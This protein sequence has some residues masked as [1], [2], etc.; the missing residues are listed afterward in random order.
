MVTY[1]HSRISTFEQCRY[2][3]KLQYIDKLESGPKTIEAFM[4]TTVHSALEKLYKDLGYQKVNSI[5]EVLEY[6]N[7]EWNANYTEGIVINKEDYTAENYRKMGAKYISD[8]YARYS[9]FDQVNIIGLETQDILDLGDGIK[10]HVRIDKFA[11]KGDEY[12]VCDYKTNQTI[13]DQKEADG[14]R[15]LAMYAAWVKEKFPDAK[16]VKLVWHML[17]F[18]KDVFSERTDQQLLELSDEIID[19]I[20]NIETCT[21]WPTNPSVLCNYCGYKSACPEFVWGAEDKEKGLKEMEE[22]EQISAE[23]AAE[24]A[25]EL[26]AIGAQIKTLENRKDEVEKKLKSFSLQNGAK[27][28]H[29]KKALIRVK[30]TEDIQLPEEK[31]GLISLL[32]EKGLYVKYSNISYGKMKSGVLKGELDQEICQLIPVVEKFTTTVSKLKD[33]SDDEGKEKE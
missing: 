13:K 12:F 20:R 11:C 17:K 7:K 3:Y 32:E 23:E 8:Y 18:D 10:Y 19:E 24:M 5:E 4:G 21:I 1:S 26:L 9:P 25:D 28:I 15:Q 2:R 16:K 33:T 29:G 30:K 22:I 27:E 14:D 6:Y 31:E